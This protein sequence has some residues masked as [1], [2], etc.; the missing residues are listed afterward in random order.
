M[1]E[2]RIKDLLNEH[3][4]KK[5]SRCKEWEA[6]IPYDSSSTWKNLNVD[7][8]MNHNVSTKAK[9][10]PLFKIR[11]SSLFSENRYE[12]AAPYDGIYTISPNTCLNNITI[13]RHFDTAKE[14]GDFYLSQYY[15]SEVVSND[16]ED[17][18]YVI[19][20]EK[21]KSLIIS[22]FNQYPHILFGID[23]S[24]FGI[25]FK[26]V[27]NSSWRKSEEMYKGD[28]IT[29]LL[30]NN[31]K[32]T[33]TSKNNPSRVAHT[34]NDL[35]ELFLLTEKQLNQLAENQIVAWKIDFFNG[36]ESFVSGRGDNNFY[37][38]AIFCAYVRKNIELLHQYNE[39]L[40]I[41][42]DT[43]INNANINKATYV[44]LMQDTTNC[45]YKIG[46]SNNPEYRER[47]LQSEKPTIELII[48]KEF[49]I[50]RIAEAFE[51][52]LHKTYEAKRLRGEWFRLD[53]KDVE[54][55]IKAMS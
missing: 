30:D 11:V 45:Y 50:R 49:P 34:K 17:N 55:L 6:R 48:A 41:T 4:V 31:E 15:S 2:Y 19:W 36:D 20:R 16:F 43:I 47:T 39:D 42:E 23:I 35:Q 27:W 51:A 40:K 3:L 13:I 12:I 1:H 54:D 5:I 14:F 21:R 22:G 7:S 9:G 33:L 24:S 32:I 53:A 8:T 44:Y 46:I 37:Q 18:Q 38:S 29:L 10:E 52:A 28:V 26:L 25:Y